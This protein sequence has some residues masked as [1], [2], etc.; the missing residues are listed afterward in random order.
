[1]VETKVH[2]GCANR[3]VKKN[4]PLFEE[5]ARARRQHPVQSYMAADRKNKSNTLSRDR[6]EV[7]F[8]VG[9][10]PGFTAKML[11]T[12][13]HL[14]G[15]AHRRAPELE[16]MGLIRRDKDGS[17]MRLYITEKGREVLGA[18]E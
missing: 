4:L 14:S 2:N 8:E 16:T 5:P 10:N 12:M 17:E 3:T 13:R 9:C 18:K 7:L 1:M 15:K 6:L 11:D